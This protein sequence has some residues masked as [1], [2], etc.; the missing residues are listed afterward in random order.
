M[1]T[2]TFNQLR[3]EGTV[4]RA[5]AMKVQLEDLHEEP[6]FNLR[7]L[8]AVDPDGVSFQD[9]I[10][11]LAEF[12]AA[13]GIYPPLEVR[14]RSEGG[15]WLVDGHRRRMALL[16]LDAQGRLP[17]APNKETG[18]LEA[19]VSI[20]PFEGNDADRVARI[21]T[22]Q[23]SRKLNDLEKANGCKRLAAFGWAPEQIAKAI[24]L[25]RQRVDQ[26][27][28]LASA[29]TDVQQMV[30]AGNVSGTVAVELVREH[31]EG[32]GKVLMEEWGKAKAAGKA[33]VTAGTMKGATVPRGLLDDMHAIATTM[34]KSFKPD[35]LVAIER[36]HRGEIT[37]GTV[38]ISLEAAMQFHLML[39]EAARVLGEKEAK[40][41][42]KANK[43]AQLEL[44][45]EGAE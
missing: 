11:A 12:I 5:D 42:E 28:I 20:V 31:G 36:Y 33:K 14:P 22:S 32:A 23:Q 6:G 26:L 10:D 8:Q 13:G 4:K 21:I 3:T 35:D 7:D 16:Q 9:G 39:E 45:Q 19:W 38:E 24:G 18:K 43:A 37:E 1:T 41:R 29:N 40:L 2:K 25:T 17:R 30:K 27:L 34:H 15:V 44:A